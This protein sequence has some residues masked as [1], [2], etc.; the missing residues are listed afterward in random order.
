MAVLTLMQKVRNVIIVSLYCSLVLLVAYQVIARFVLNIP[1]AWAEELARSIFIYCVFLSGS[2]AI[3]RKA[4]VAF[5]LILDSLKGKPWKLMYTISFVLSMIF[6][7]MMFFFGILLMQKNS[8]VVS[9]LL[10]IPTWSINMAIP[11]GALL[12]VLSQIVIYFKTMKEKHSD[13]LEN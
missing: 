7:I 3:E 12:M 13:L 8:I 4:N 5:D 6:I 11:I 1:A 2:L 10:K 9:P